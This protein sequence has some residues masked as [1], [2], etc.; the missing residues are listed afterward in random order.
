MGVLHF[1]LCN[2]ET[3]VLP[4]EGCVFT[5]YDLYLQNISLKK[6]KCFTKL[7]RAPS[8]GGGG[9]GVRGRVGGGSGQNHYYDQKN[10]NVDRVSNFLASG[11]SVIYLVLL[12]SY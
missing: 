4:S 1:I 2:N 12:R 3:V 6:P 9:V 11:H 10:G 7:I 8:F 5:N